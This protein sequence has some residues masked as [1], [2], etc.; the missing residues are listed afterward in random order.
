MCALEIENN[1]LLL[2]GRTNLASCCW[3][4]RFY[5]KN[6]LLVVG[7]GNKSWLC[8]GM[9][10]L[11]GLTKL[12]RRE[13]GRERERESRP[14]GQAGGGKNNAQN[15]SGKNKGPQHSR[16]PDRFPRALP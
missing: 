16:K 11:F 14:A 9:F 12:N 8:W 5:A 15:G 7:W 6:V 3:F 10:T 4:T 1:L 13:I 2:V